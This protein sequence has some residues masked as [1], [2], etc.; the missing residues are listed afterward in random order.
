VNLQVVAPHLV[1]DAE[2][3]SARKAL[4]HV[5]NA[6]PDV[7]SAGDDSSTTLRTPFLHAVTLV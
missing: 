4:V 2:A 6:K 1:A 3:S 5:M 7:R